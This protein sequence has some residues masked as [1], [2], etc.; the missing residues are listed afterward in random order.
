MSKKR[1]LIAHILGAEGKRMLRQ[2]D[3]IEVVE[4]ANTIEQGQFQALLESFDA[5]HGVILG[6]TRF[7]AAELQR[8]VGLE[9]VSRIGVGFDAVDIPAMTEAAIPVMVCANANHRAVAEHTLG[10]MLSLA[11]RTEALSHLVRNGDWHHRYDYL[12]SELEDREVLLVGCGRIGTRVATLLM[13]LGMRVKVYDPYLSPQQLPH[14]VEPV[15]VLENGLA[16]ADYVSL[17]CPKTAETIGLLSAERMALMKPQAYLINTARGGI[18]DEKALHQAL[19]EKRIAGAALDVFLPEPPPHDSGLPS[20][21][22][23]ICSPHLAGVSQEAVSRMAKLAAGNVLDVF[24]AKPIHE[25]AVNPQVFHRAF[26]LDKAKSADTIP[27][28]I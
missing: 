22:N 25:N 9:V 7:G 12:P 18:V 4:F 24:D 11:K 23:V 19:V 2:R 21:D 5:V 14:G 13:A 27:Y 1:V 26:H 16:S 20:L 10:F 15:A 17:H 3:D 6:L 8:A 28:P